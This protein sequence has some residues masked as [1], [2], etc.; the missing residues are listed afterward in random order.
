[1]RRESRAGS[2]PGSENTSQVSSVRE[3]AGR[4]F[5]E[6]LQHREHVSDVCAI[7]KVSDLDI[8]WDKSPC[9]L[10]SQSVDIT[11]IIRGPGCTQSFKR[12]LTYREGND[13]PG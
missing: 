6:E 13:P 12:G 11:E 7:K 3:T 4:G 2:T 9:E 8:E 10:A 5:I 1:V